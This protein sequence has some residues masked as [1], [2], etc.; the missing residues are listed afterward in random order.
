VTLSFSGIVLAGGK[1]KRLGK[2]KAFIEL[3]GKP[4]IQWV[5]DALRDLCDELLISANEIELYSGLGVRVVRDAPSGKG[6]L[7]GLYSALIEMRNDFTFVA[8]CDM[9]FLSKALVSYMMSRARDC[10][11]LVPRIDAYIDPLHAIY[12]KNCVAAIEKQIASGNRQVRSF[13]GDIKV[14]YV[15]KEIIYKLDPG[16]LSLFNINNTADL[17][18]ARALIA[19]RDRGTHH[20]QSDTININR[21]VIREIKRK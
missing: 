19:G 8:A 9:P 6:A 16:G 17:D 14:K 18:K 13:Y 12:S 10:D 21:P 15:D 5:L 11:A 2:N 7:V 3:G 4:V 1:S 20:N